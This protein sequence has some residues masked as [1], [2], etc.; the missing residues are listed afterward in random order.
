MNCFKPTCTRLR[1]TCREGN[2]G[3]YLFLLLSSFTT[4]SNKLPETKFDPGKMGAASRKNMR[5]AWTH[6]LESPEEAE[7]GTQPVTKQAMPSPI[8]QDPRRLGGALF[9]RER[10]LDYAKQSLPQYKYTLA[11]YTTFTC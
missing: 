9:S 8:S 7:I 3:D 2:T 6:C 10:F 4:C 5:S 11:W 1:L